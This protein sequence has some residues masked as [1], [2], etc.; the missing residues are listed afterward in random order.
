[1]PLSES[2]WKCG[3]GR[4]PALPGGLFFLTEEVLEVVHEVVESVDGLCVGT[5]FALHGGDDDFVAEGE[6]FEVGVLVGVIEFEALG[7]E[8][9]EDFVLYGL[10]VGLLVVDPASELV[11]I[12]GRI[13][14]EFDDL[15]GGLLDG[16]PIGVHRV[17]DVVVRVNPAGD[18]AVGVGIWSEGEG[19]EGSGSEGCDVSDVHGEMTLRE[20]AGGARMESRGGGGAGTR[21]GGAPRYRTLLR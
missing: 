20:K 16:F 15:G 9:V 7:E 21:R 11:D 4:R 14:G 6:F 1:M 18:L 2:D 17:D 13:L 3:A 12:L 5:L 10:G 19:C 8:V